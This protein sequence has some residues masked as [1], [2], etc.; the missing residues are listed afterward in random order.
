MTSFAPTMASGFPVAAFHQHVRAAGEDQRERRVFIEP[1]D[2]VHR[3]QGREHRHAVLE[4]VD[5]P[6]LAF[7]QA[8][9]RGV[10]V[11][12]DHEARAQGARLR[13]VGDVAA[14]QDIENA[15]GEYQ[16]AGEGCD[17]AGKLRR[18]AQLRFEFGPL[19]IGRW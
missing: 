11:G 17:P 10:A 14:M 19:G 4:A 2:Q 3:L 7:A 8:P 16:R 9:G 5:R 15:V 1:G 13:E 6:V 12:C 18:F